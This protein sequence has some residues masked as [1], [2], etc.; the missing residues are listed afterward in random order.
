MEAHTDDCYCIALHATGAPPTIAVG[1]KDSIVSFWDLE[2]M[3]CLRTILRHTTPVRCLAFSAG[4]RYLASSAYDPGVDIADAETTDLVH[5][6][7]AQ[8]AMNSLAWH[9]QKPVLAYA[10]DAKSAA[11]DRRGRDEA[12]PPYVRLFACPQQAGS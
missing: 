4:G 6:I 3:L 2:E 1:S 12:T 9:P 7:D 5:T 8:H 10:I 11:S